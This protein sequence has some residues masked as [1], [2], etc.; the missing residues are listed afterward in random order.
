MIGR[1]AVLGG[2]VA[3]V[4]MPSAVHAQRTSRIPRLGVLIFSEP[5]TDP[6]T[7]AMREGLRERG[8]VEGQNLLIEY[9]Y[10]EGHAER[11]RDLATD[12]VRTKP[13][14]IFVL[15]TDVAAF[16]KAAT[17]TI[18]IV[19]AMSGDPV[20]AKLVPSF[21][22][23][24]G[25]LTGV[26]FLTSEVAGKRLQLLKQAVPRVARVA[27]LWSAE[28]PDDELNETQSA[29]RALGVQVVSSEMR[30]ASELDGALQAAVSA[31]ADAFMVVPS[32]FTVRL[33]AAQIDFATRHKLPL[34]GGWGIWAESGALLSYG[35]DVNAMVRRAT[36]HVDRILK[37]AKPSELPVE[38]PTSFELVVN[39]K[40]ARALGITMP[41][42]VLLQADRVIQ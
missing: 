18:P 9:R 28:H 3:T 27:V 30:D 33:R 14:V 25:N 40:T 22:A 11:L 19:G 29:A 35:P 42:T 8:Y 1:R 37:G 36:G 6:N 13:D 17:S 10:A 26:T 39:L 15:G 32:R 16:A 34:A 4:L 2:A 31:G 12:L 5:Q 21:A 24:G 20:R 41:Q 7:Q 38:Q 23:P